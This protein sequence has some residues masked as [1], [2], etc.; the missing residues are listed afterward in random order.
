MIETWIQYTHLEKL[1]GY[2]PGMDE[3]LMA[4]LF[5]LGLEEYREVKGRFDTNARDAAKELL[6]D[7][8]F[9]GRVDRPAAVQVGG[10]R[11]GRGRQHHGRSAVLARDSAPPA[12]RA[13]TAGRD[14]RRQRWPLRAHDGHGAQALR[15][16][17][18]RAGARSDNLPPWR[19]RR[20]PDRAGA[21]QATGGPRGD[22]QEPGG[23][24][25][26]RR[27]AD[28]AEWVWITSPTY[29]EQRASSFPPFK[30]G[31]LVFRNDGIV[32]IGDLVRAQEDA[33]VD[34]QA[35]FGLPA[36]PELQGP[37]GV[38]PSLAGQ[39]AIARAFVERL[40]ESPG[41]GVKKA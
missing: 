11:G 29:D 4:R 7:A 25:A 40:T 26:H 37:D 30:M 23:H 24:A 6:E 36:D 12:R 38:H 10:D 35:V 8:S 19:Q 9:A 20:H 1:Y 18:G 39:R 13:A 28:R 3:A 27:G 2:Q 5:G 21:E 31:Q 41:E 16:D 14:T 22:G 17:G 32:A 15:P 34:V 33:V